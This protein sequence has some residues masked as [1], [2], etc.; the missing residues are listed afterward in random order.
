MSCTTTTRLRETSSLTVRRALRLWQNGSSLQN[1][2]SIVSVIYK[3]AFF[4]SANP[5]FLPNT[6]QRKHTPSLMEWVF[7]HPLFLTNSISCGGSFPPCERFPP[8]IAARRRN[9]MRDGGT[10]QSG[11]EKP[12][13]EKREK[14]MCRS[15][16]ARGHFTLM[17]AGPIEMTAALHDLKVRR[18]RIIFQWWRRGIGGVKWCLST[19]PPLL[20]PP[21]HRHHSHPP[22]WIIA[23][24]PRWNQHSAEPHHHYAY[25][26]APPWKQIA[27]LLSFPVPI[28][29]N[30]KYCHWKFRGSV[31]ENKQHDEP[32]GSLCGS[33]QRRA[34]LTACHSA[35]QSFLFAT[36][37]A[38]VFVFILKK[39][40]MSQKTK[41]WDDT[42]KLFLFFLYP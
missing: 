29:H 23:E 14:K 4:F 10:E 16:V 32:P 13:W 27:L 36:V 7:F 9:R 6:V 34:A 8:F 1:Q 42:D 5:F 26:Q 39:Q 18:Q 11:G 19:T 41:Y 15:R 22:R 21:P 3:A 31:C 2:I 33:L 30:E 12:R 24:P 20:A 28:H 40:M 35:T 38:N 37:P 25:T 17:A